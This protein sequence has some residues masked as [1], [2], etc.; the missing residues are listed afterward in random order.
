MKSKTAASP[1]A[2]R[3]ARLS[4][5][6]VSAAKSVTGAARRKKVGSV[7]NNEI[8]RAATGATAKIAVGALHGI[9]G[10]G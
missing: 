9:A 10:Q 6:S 1:H 7:A 8:V 5:A 4:L 2:R 3:L